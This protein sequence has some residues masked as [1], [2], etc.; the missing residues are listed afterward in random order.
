MTCET[1][2]TRA[3]D[4]VAK[5]HYD[6]LMVDVFINRVHGEQIL[7]AARR[8]DPGAKVIMMSA[9]G[10]MEMWVDLMNKGAVDLVPKPFQATNLK[11]TVSKFME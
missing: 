6:L 3:L 7:N 8:S 5:E 1:D 11:R 10:D 4:L 9:Y 2:G